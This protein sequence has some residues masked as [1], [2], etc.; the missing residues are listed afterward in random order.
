MFYFVQL[1]ATVIFVLQ[2]STNIHLVEF[3]LSS[4][5]LNTTCNRMD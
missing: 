5:G 2:A 1:L 3:E 4:N